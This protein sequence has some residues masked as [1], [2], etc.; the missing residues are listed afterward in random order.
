VCV[1]IRFYPTNHRIKNP[2]D[3][4]SMYNGNKRSSSTSARQLFLDDI[5]ET[6]EYLAEM[7]EH[8]KEICESEELEYPQRGRGR[9]GMHP[10]FPYALSF[11]LRGYSPQEAAE[12]YVQ[13]ESGRAIE[14]V[15]SDPV[16]CC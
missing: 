12:K 14:P 6:R 10:N 2:K 7:Q 1:T 3:V 8:I 4:K 9:R 11:R 16:G 15:H 5:A 13:C